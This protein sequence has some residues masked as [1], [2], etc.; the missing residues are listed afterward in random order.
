M[1]YQDWLDAA[2]TAS[3]EDLRERILTGFKDGKPF[4]P[5]APTI[6]LPFPAARVLDFGCGLG[7]NF[8]FLRSRATYLAG[9]DLPPMIERCRTL[10][11]EGADQ[12]SDDWRSLRADRFDLIFSALVLQHIDRETSE[13]Y[14]VDFAAMAPYTYLLTR[15]QS[16]F[17]HNVLDLMRRLNVFDVVAFA[18][19]EHDDRTHQL[20]AT[21]QTRIEDAL[22]AGDMRHFEALLRRRE[23]DRQK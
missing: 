12:L 6:S 20:R 1:A 8:P 5:Y 7:R 16:D 9:F 3:E 21:G 14:F 13:A 18:V 11:P 22:G 4:T 19:V 23:R 10:I 17:E 2:R 15:A